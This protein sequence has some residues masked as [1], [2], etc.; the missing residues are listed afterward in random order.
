MS[1]A[2]GTDH[3]YRMAASVQTTISRFHCAICM[4]CCQPS[5]QYGCRDNSR[6]NCVNQTNMSHVQSACLAAEIVPEEI[7]LLSLIKLTGS[8]LSHERMFF[9]AEGGQTM[10]LCPFWDVH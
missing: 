4:P 9:E 5:L 7:A 1:F 8:I 2:A 10:P 3:P 6:V